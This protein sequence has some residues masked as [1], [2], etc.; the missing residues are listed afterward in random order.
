MPRQPLWIRPVRVP[1]VPMIH[2]IDPGVRYAL[3]YGRLPDFRLPA[4]RGSKRL[5]VLFAASADRSRDLWRQHREPILTVWMAAHPGTRP[6]AWWWYDAPEPHRRRVGGIG[7]GIEVFGHGQ[8]YDC[9]IPRYWV[10]D[11][12][13]DPDAA[14]DPDDGTSID[15]EDPPR[16]ESQAAY[17]DHHQLLTREERGRLRRKDFERDAIVEPDADELDT[18]R[19]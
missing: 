12:D 1:K 7:D 8:A 14:R 4:F 17:L 18:E 9:G 6:A 16:F 10:Q 13:D 15:P 5:A 3:E 19:A 11:G 2:E